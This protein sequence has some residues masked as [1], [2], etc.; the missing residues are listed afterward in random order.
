MFTMMFLRMIIMAPIMAVGGVI[1]AYAKDAK[2]MWVLAIVIPI[3]IAVGVFVATRALPLFRA[4]QKKIDRLNLVLREGLTGVRVV[5]AFNRVDHERVRFDE[6]NK[7]L[8]ETSVKVNKLMA[9]MMPLMMLI[10]NIT[11]VAIIWFGA[12]RIDAGEMQVG[13]L[14]A[15]LQYGMQIL[16]SL[17][18]VSFLFIMLPRASA[19]GARIYEVLELNPS[20]KDPEAPVHGGAGARIP[21][22]PQR[23]IRISGGRRA[24]HQRHL[25][26]RP[27]GR[28]DGNH[29][30]HRLGQIDARQS[31]AALLR[32]RTGRD[33]RGRR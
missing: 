13:G 6:A 24:C 23:H 9:L 7:D 29:R 12:Q 30:R 20:I 28:S 27:S 5:R 4:I 32:R 19:S 15:F 11:M 18:M 33:P 8:T 26:Q 3:I 1:M 21:G 10:M 16:F 25:L 31:R 14:M 17:L 22:V 2:L